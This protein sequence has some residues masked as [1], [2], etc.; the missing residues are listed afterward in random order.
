M[1]TNYNQLAQYYDLIH[2]ELTADIAFIITLASGKR[3][4]ILDLGCGTGRLVIPLAREGHTVFGLEASPEM[5]AI[6]KDKFDREPPGIQSQVT[7]LEGDMTSFHLGRQFDLI[8]ISHNT[9]NE[10]APVSAASVL[11]QIKKQLNPDGIVFIDLGNPFLVL[12]QHDDDY[13][14]VEDRTFHDPETGF[15]LH[16]RSTVS[17]DYRRQMAHVEKV[18]IPQPT[19]AIPGTPE[20]DETDFHMIYPHELD[21]LLEPAGLQLAQLYGGYAGEPFSEKSE[22]MIAIAQHAIE[23][24][25]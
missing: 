24:S 6:A 7:W 16:Q 20:T 8:T 12:Q 2:A 19:E 1:A 9:L 18:L 3:W 11:V 22:R 17:L 23:R 15:L 25:V 4:T 14:W 21:L 10:F 13:V 5:L